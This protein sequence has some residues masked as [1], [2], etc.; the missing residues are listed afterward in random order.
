MRSNVYLFAAAIL[1]AT[2]IPALATEMAIG[3]DNTIVIYS[4]AYADTTQDATYGNP[5]SETYASSE[6]V[7]YL[8]ETAPARMEFV[9]V[10]ADI[11]TYS[12]EMTYSSETIYGSELTYAPETVEATY[13]GES[14]EDAPM[15]MTETIDG[16]VYETVI[17]TPQTY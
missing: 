14:I 10:P 13:A 3:D 16:I 5:Y 12:P 15:S 8:V 17:A 4:D 2:S 6:E 7:T 1:A 11:S 9:E